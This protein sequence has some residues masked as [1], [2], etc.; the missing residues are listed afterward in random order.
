M[1]SAAAVFV[2]LRAA[3][4]ADPYPH[5]LACHSNYS[6]EE[7]MPCAAALVTLMQRAP[8]S[9]LTACFKKY[10]TTKLLEVSKVV[11]PPLEVIEEARRLSS[12]L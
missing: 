11:Q 12:G 3:G 8:T 10:S 5:A 9:T 7:I 6:R 1:T 2:S 4:I